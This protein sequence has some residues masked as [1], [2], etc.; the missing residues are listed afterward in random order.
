MAYQLK[1][2]SKSTSTD[3]LIRLSIDPQGAEKAYF[4][5]YPH[6]YPG[7]YVSAK[8]QPFMFL[9]YCQMSDEVREKAFEKYHDNIDFLNEF[10]RSTPVQKITSEH[11]KKMFATYAQSRD[12][13]DV[14][15]GLSQFNSLNEDEQWDIIQ[16]TKVNKNAKALL[17][18]HS[19]NNVAR[20]IS[21]Q[22]VK[23]GDPELLE[24]VQF[25][26][27]KGIV[28]TSKEDMVDT[29]VQ[30]FILG[31]VWSAKLDVIKK[32]AK[33]IKA[34]I[35]RDAPLF[36]SN[37]VD[38]IRFGLNILAT[39]DIEG[40]RMH[41]VKLPEPYK[42]NGIR[43]I[44]ETLLLEP[45]GAKFRRLLYDAGFITSYWG[46]MKT[47]KNPIPE[48]QIKAIARIFAL[49]AQKFPE[50][51]SALCNEIATCE[52]Y[53]KYKNN[54]DFYIK[55]MNNKDYNKHDFWLKKQVFHVNFVK[56]M[57]LAH[58][59][60]QTPLHN[61]KEPLLEFF[62]TTFL[63]ELLSMKELMGYKPIAETMKGF[64]SHLDDLELS[65][66][67]LTEIIVLCSSNKESHEIDL[68]IDF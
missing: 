46:R 4:G 1:N 58:M 13:A 49:T 61:A 12:L 41:L 19:N 42:F 3:W 47:R 37:N 43:E 65:K 6:S 64:H 57:M 25:N 63:D 28:T 5:Y 40:A 30:D 59:M 45:E 68:I 44:G 67:L 14:I 29:F 53:R 55:E 21:E 23:E 7:G 48:N 10:H 35:T 34:I 60:Y 54:R 8:D 9:L 33:K 27:A 36:K 50:E 39:K 66:T 24:I 26:H 56:T 52:E 11:R 32:N 15:A 16:K 62:D 51:W 17:A 20:Y 31:K 22:I 18:V 2:K 38:A